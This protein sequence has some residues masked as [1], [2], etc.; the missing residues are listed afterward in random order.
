MRRRRFGLLLATLAVF[1]PLAGAQADRLG[2]T[3][4]MPGSP[5]RD[6]ALESARPPARLPPGW[7]AVA[8]EHGAL[9]LQAV[10]QTRPSDWSLVTTRTPEEP[11][12]AAAMSRPAPSSVLEPARHAL[13]LPPGALFGFRFA[14]DTTA[15]RSVKPGAHTS[16]VPATLLRVDTRLAV[17]RGDE[18]WTITTESKT[19][20][21]GALLAGS[22][23]LVATNAQGQRRVLV[24][25]ADGMA[26][27]RQELLWLGTLAGGGGLDLLLRRTWL[28][29]QVEHVLVVGGAAGHG[30]DD[31]DRPYAV[32]ASGI[33]ATS[34][35]E[36]HR[37][38]P[39]QRPGER[40][41]SAAFA[42]DEEAWNRELQR[43]EGAGA[44]GTLLDRRLTLAGEALRFTVEHL[45]RWRAAEAEANSSPPDRHWSGPLL[46]KVH[47]RG[48]SQVLLETGA[49]DGGPTRVQVDLLNG[50]PAV[51]LQIWPHY[52]NNFLHTWVWSERDGRFLR[53]LTRQD[54]GC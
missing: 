12:G 42:V 43:L 30:V 3:L 9:R 22:L 21:D 41:G 39:R 31:A 7:F 23:A 35:L 37:D 34:G 26:F 13:D 45:P 33:E 6:A 48:R 28:T 18:R 50:E 25:P 2:L 19:R 54:Q 40:F 11:A 1:S 24:P 46:V 49:L 5:L 15:A 53:L 8:L 36:R 29:G 14:A 44:A 51:Q 17:V 38:Q 32:F 16:L 20:P 10:T 4:S 47:F 52:N 27:A